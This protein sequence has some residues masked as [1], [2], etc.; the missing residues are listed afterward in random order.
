[1]LAELRYLRRSHRHIYGLKNAL[2]PFV[3]QFPR[4]EKVTDADILGY[5]NALP[6]QIGPRRRDNIRDSNVQLFR[7]A[8]RRDYLPEDRR[9]AA[10]KIRRFSHGPD[11][12]LTW[13]VEESKLLLEHADRLWL[14]YFATGLFA[15]LRSSEIYRLDWGAFKWDATD[16]KGDPSP[17]IAV[18]RSIA[19]KTRTDRLVPILP[20]LESWLEPYRNRIG[21]LY[22]GN[23]KTRENARCAE[24]VRI[25]RATGLS[26][27]DNANRHSFGSYRLAVTKSYDQVA[28][29]MGNSPLKVRMNYNDPKPEKEGLDYFKLSRP[30]LDNVVPMNLALEFC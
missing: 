6:D 29:E 27:K 3:K 4:L 9:T 12:V 14:P 26:R 22:P 10:E 19:K 20:N 23:I 13:T 15:G 16:Q 24:L 1:M 2:E 25:R 11:K 30:Q 28:R 5:L 17:Y 8:R 18:T 7:F 21:P